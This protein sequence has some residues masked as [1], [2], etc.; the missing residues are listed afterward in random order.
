MSKVVLFGEPMALL[1]SEEEGQIKD[2]T[3]FRKKVAGAELNVCIGLN[4]LEHTPIFITRLG[5]NDPFGNYIYDTLKSENLDMTN[6]SMDDKK[7]TGFMLKNRVLKGDPEIFYYRKNSAAS[8]ISPKDLNNIKFDEIDQVHV[9]GIACAV[10]ESCLLT[11]H[12][13]VDRAKSNGVF[14]SFDPNIR[15]S[16]WPDEETMIS[17]INDIAFKSDMVMPGITEGELLTGENTPE[18]IADFYMNKGVKIVIVKT[19]PNGCYY[20]TETGSGYVDG[21]KVDKVVDTVGAGDAFACGVISG[22]L[23]GL[24]AEKYVMRGNIMGAMQVQVE[25]D[26]EGLPTKEVLLKYE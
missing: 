3:N 18:G 4:R 11:A 19:G 16:L 8:N 9:T 21:V 2:V 24:S 22:R 17:S 1:I 5:K 14:V 7:L 23:E 6:I 26:N 12:V 10:S 20:K 13:L 25:G 15:K